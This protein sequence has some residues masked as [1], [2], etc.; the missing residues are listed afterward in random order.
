MEIESVDAGPTPPWPRLEDF[1]FS[2][3]TT[4]LGH[5]RHQSYGA[6]LR[7]PAG[8]D[9]RTRLHTPQRTGYQH[10]TARLR[11]AIDEMFPMPPYSAL[12]LDLLRVVERRM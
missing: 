5:S 1:V 4:A 7:A 12:T 3:F 9:L 8:A 2:A 11:T 6:R 10:Q